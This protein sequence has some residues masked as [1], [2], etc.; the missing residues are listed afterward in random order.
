MSILKYCSKEPRDYQR[1]VL[2]QVERDWH[3]TDVFVLNCPTGAGKT[4]L[5]ETIAKWSKFASIITPTN[6]LVEQFYQDTKGI[7]KLVTSDRYRCGTEATY[8]CKQ[9]KKA[10]KY[11][12][13]GICEYNADL[14]KAKWGGGIGVYTYYMYMANKLFRSN[15]ISDEAHNLSKTIIDLATIKYWQHDIKY[16]NSV[17]NRADLI[18]WMQDSGGQDKYPEL[19]Q[20]AVSPAPK[21]V[22][23]L[24]KDWYNGKGT[25]KGAPELR[26]LIKMHPVDIT[27]APKYFWPNKVRKIIL[28]SATINYKDIE[29]LGLDKRAVTY[30]NVPSPI[31]PYRRRVVREYVGAINYGN[32]DKMLPLVAE[33][34]TQILG[35][36]PGQKGMIHAPYSFANKLYPLIKSKRILTHDKW[37]TMQVF[38]AFKDMPPE[39]GAVLLASGLTE[40]V[41]L[42]MDAARFQIIAKSPWLS[43]S[44][45]AIKFAQEQDPEWYV[46]NSLKDTIQ[47]CGRVCRGPEDEGVTYIVDSSFERMLS[48]YPDLVPGWFNESLKAGEQIVDNK[49]K[50]GT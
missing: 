4:L 40:G 48:S 32:T 39:S 37:N 31:E 20:E 49:L 2:L 29:G 41:D 27:N 23:E 30:I 5:A 3:K 12:C 24:T 16:P 35:K 17:K 42:P 7:N 8:S 14:R 46:W 28:L 50:G 18:K 6:L 9:M 22:L 34:I 43:L 25:G 19:Y 47:A 15:L 45:P 21:Y 36:Y 38:R 13:K 11:Y 1:E 10:T 33:K 44:D 26:P